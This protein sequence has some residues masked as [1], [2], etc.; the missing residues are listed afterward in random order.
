MKLEKPFSSGISEDDFL[1][2]QWGSKNHI[3]KHS[4]AVRLQRVAR[5]VLQ[6]H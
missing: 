5:E 3:Q 1:R 2:F 6:K 4:K